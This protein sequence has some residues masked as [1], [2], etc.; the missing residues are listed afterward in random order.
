MLRLVS[1]D[2][3]LTNAI[4]L[5]SGDQAGYVSGKV[6]VVSCVGA[7]PPASITQISRSV[8]PS[9]SKLLAAYAILVPSGD[10]VGSCLAVELLV[11]GVIPLPSAF[12]TAIWLLLFT[13]AILLPSGEIA[14]SELLNET[15]SLLAVP[16][17]VM[18]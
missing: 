14:G 1:P 15:V 10:Q 16:P 2:R 18:V 9:T 8:C 6:L 13:K 5:P 4:W 11:S 7:P 12:I 3:V 17:G